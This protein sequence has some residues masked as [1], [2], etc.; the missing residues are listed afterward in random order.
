MA[1]SKHSPVRTFL[2]EPFD[3]MLYAD[4]EGVKSLQ[5]RF[6]TWLRTLSGPARFFCWQREASLDRKIAQVSREARQTGDA[7]RAELLMEYRRHYEMLESSADFQQT[8]CGMALWSDEMPRA[9][10]GGMM[11]AFDTPVY[12]APLAPL[13]E[14]RYDLK[15]TP[16][17]HL[18]PVGRPGGR[19]LIAIMTSY[20][21]LPV[22]WTFRVPLIETIRLNMP[23]ALVIDIPKTLERNAAVDAVENIIAAYQVHLA[24][25]RGEDS[26][27]VTRINDCRRT[28]QEINAGDALHQVQFSYAI[29]AHDADELKRRMQQVI[30]LTRPWF[31]LRQEVGELL[32]RA[33]QFFSHT[34]SKEI[35]VPPTTWPMTSREL[36]LALGLTGE[37]KLST[38]DG[39]L[40]GE[41]VEAAYPVFY[42]SWRDRR[43]TH[44]VWVGSSGYGKTFLLNGYLCRE[45]AEA[46]IPFD[47]LE[48]MG[49][50]Q[51]HCRHL[52]LA[53]VRPQRA[54]Y[55]SEPA[56]RDVPHAHRAEIAHD[57]H[58]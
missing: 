42:N 45:Y 43:A 44:E 55:L 27:S 48:P 30:S 6:A 22:V 53:L 13:F 56:G 41:A 4:D 32:A 50:G 54:A 8:L 36:A 7:Q 33:V 9:L 3:I 46:G 18:E 15:E 23:M 39:V 12:E 57:S 1:D 25:V 21:L 31:L 16:F 28:L 10:A 26:R 11:A 2:I 17:W 24:S 51:P 58:L 19:P 37:R 47:F 40:R 14:G 38:T 29:F 20:E 35:N 49:H 5:S 34:A 52:R